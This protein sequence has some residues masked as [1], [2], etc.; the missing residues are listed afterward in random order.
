MSRLRINERN[1]RDMLELVRFQK[2]YLPAAG[3]G[4][5]ICSS[6]EMFVSERKN[7]EKLGG[8]VGMSIYSIPYTQIKK[9]TALKKYDFKV[10]NIGRDCYNKIN[11]SFLRRLYICAHKPLC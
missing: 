3:C 11:I 4:E 1:G 8:L 7:R 5:L 9:I 2:K 6:R 10:D